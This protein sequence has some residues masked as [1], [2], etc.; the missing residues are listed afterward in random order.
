MDPHDPA[1]VP[2]TLGAPSRRRVLGGALALP[3]ALALE[4]RQGA[5]GGA[6]G[7]P[8]SQ[9]G[10]QRPAD[11]PAGSLE[12]F[13]ERWIGRARALVAQED[14]NEDAFLHELCGDLLRCDPAVFPRRRFTVYSG[15]G[16]ETGPVGRDDVL[17]LVEIVLEPG[18]VV[19]AHNHVSYA[20][21][22]FC[23]EGEARVR[24]FEPEPGSPGPAEL[25]QDFQVRE[26]QDVL[27]RPGRCSTLSRTRANVH[28]IVAGPEGARLLDL[29]IRFPVGGPGPRV[30]SVLEVDPE[31]ADAARGA[32]TARWLGNV[33]AKGY[34]RQR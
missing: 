21:V 5:A 18:A 4:L 23:L 11:A 26:V 10:E 2:Q 19:P 33:Y 34:R 28:A 30:F 7:P 16:M 29:G 15:E 9:E 14:P 31:P 25:E 8:G 22:T 6:S 20:F 1:D 17:Q 24:H 12:P 32:Y 27:L 13:L 3:A